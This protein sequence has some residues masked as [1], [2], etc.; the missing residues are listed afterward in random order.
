MGISNSPD[1]FQNKIYQLMD[2]LKYVQAF[3][4][5]ILIETKITYEDHLRKLDTDLQKLHAANLK[6]NIEKSTFVTTLFEYLG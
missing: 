5:N 2:G 4:E 1:I 3:L 6:V